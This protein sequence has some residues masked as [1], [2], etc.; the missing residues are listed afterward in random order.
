MHFTE[1]KNYNKL[2]GP[3]EDASISLRMGK[4]KTKQSQGGREKETWVGKGAEVEERD[5]MICHWVGEKD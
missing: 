1:L 4:Q 2:K 5:N 3:T